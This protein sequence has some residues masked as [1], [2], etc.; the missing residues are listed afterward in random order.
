MEEHHI[1]SPCCVY[2]TGDRN[3]ARPVSCIGQHMRCDLGPTVL[4]GTYRKKETEK[5][6]RAVY[7]QAA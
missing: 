6:V 2:H 1:I 5:M 4:Y 7:R 3:S